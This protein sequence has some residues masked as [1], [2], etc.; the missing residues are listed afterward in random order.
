MIMRYVGADD[1]HMFMVGETVKVDESFTYQWFANPPSKANKNP[2]GEDKEE[3]KAEEGE[4]GQ[5]P[6][7]QTEAEDK[8]TQLRVLADVL[9]EP[10]LRY[11]KVPRLGSYMTVLLTRKVY[12]TEE[13]LNSAY[14]A[15]V[16]T[17]KKKEEQENEKKEKLEEIEKER[18][19]KAEAEESFHEPELEWPEIVEP[20]YEH[21]EA[22]CYVCLDTLGQDREFTDEQKNFT[23]DAVKYVGKCWEDGERRRLT[24]DK[25]LCLEIKHESDVLKE[26]KEKELEE[27]CEK[28]IDD[29]L[30]PEVNEDEQQ[31]EEQEQSKEELDEDEKA[32]K[33]EEMK[34]RFMV[35]SI[36]TGEYHDQ[37]IK[38]KDFN[39]LKFP[40]VM[41]YAF[42]VLEYDREAI[43]EVG[44][45]KLK[46]EKARELVNED[47]FK[48]MEEYTPYGPKEGVYPTYRLLN[49]LEKGLEDVKEEELAEYS[50]ALVK[51]LRWIKEVIRVR[52]ADIYARRMKKQEE[53]EDREGQFKKQEEHEAQRAEELAA[54]LKEEE[55]RYNAEIEELRAENDK[56]DE[57]EY[58]EFP[59]QPPFEANENELMKDWDEANPPVVIPEE[60]QDDVDNDYVGDIPPSAESS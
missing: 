50:F 49:T 1:E 60:V 4:A 53:R 51:L 40:R 11:F 14:A 54:R 56:K 55:E 24:H 10:N 21:G 8:T 48:R 42:Y 43:C 29:F 35:K 46:W 26:T 25:E 23:T 58:E 44:T 41:Q 59:E 28:E 15:Y 33:A 9:K 16:D 5:V 30:N 47:F 12:L 2:E 32:A 22:T 18:E 39:I 13:L 19:E 57:F 3:G 20:P 27:Q 31:N 6:A 36:T 7:E 17:L 45:N 52:K 37:L 38:L 34:Y